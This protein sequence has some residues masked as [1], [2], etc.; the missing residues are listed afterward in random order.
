MVSLFINGPG[1]Y[2]KQ[3]PSGM[4]G[5]ELLVNTLFE[6]AASRILSKIKNQCIHISTL[7]RSA[8][9]QEYYIKHYK[10]LNQCSSSKDLP[11]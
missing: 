5:L 11:Q 6:R 10:T 4:E 7:R 8:P 1:P 3:V 9:S 2:H